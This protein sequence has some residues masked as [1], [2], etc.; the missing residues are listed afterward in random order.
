M[1]TSQ[2]GW[3]A[4]K[5]LPRREFVVNGVEFVGGIR[6]DDNVEYVFRYFAEEYAKRVEPL[7]D[8]GCWGFY[9]KPNT[10]DPSSLSNHSSGTAL[11]FDAPE[12]PNKVPTARTFTP[13]QIAEVHK[14]LAE[15]H[16]ALRWGGDYTHTVDAMHVEIVVSDHALVGVVNLMKEQHPKR[17][18]LPVRKAIK[19][20][21]DAKKTAGPIQKKKLDKAEAD[22]KAIKKR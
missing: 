18:P 21:E 1:S 10:N 13:E 16:G 19:A 9:F 6:D 8:P 11:D 5:N 15:C 7:K 3:S 20:V 12:H 14:I 2:N 17:R 22:L 4:S